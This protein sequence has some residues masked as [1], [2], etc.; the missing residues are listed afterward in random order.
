MND[1]FLAIWEHVE[2]Y[3]PERAAF[4]TW[5]SAVTRY[6]IMNYRR[7]LMNIGWENDINVLQVVGE[8]DV[9]YIDSE[10]EKAEFRE[11][12]QSLPEVDQEIFMRLFWEEQ[13][14]DEISADMKIPREQLYN[15]VSRGKRRLQKTLGKKRR[16]V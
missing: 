14:Y 5:V 1:V 2:D 3:D 8:K 15:H 13:D 7:K 12:L 4:T 16:L 10:E 11:L 9:S 6:R